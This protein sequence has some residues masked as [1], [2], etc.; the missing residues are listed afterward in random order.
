MVKFPTLLVVLHLLGFHKASS[1]LQE[2]RTANA[3]V[4]D[5]LQ[6]NEENGDVV[7]PFKLCQKAYKVIANGGTLATITHFK[8][9]LLWQQIHA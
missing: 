8:K 5:N 3:Y 7:G 4:K 9:K 2:V 1:S 6:Q